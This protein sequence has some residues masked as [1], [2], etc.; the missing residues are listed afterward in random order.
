MLVM[1]EFNEDIG[2]RQ[3]AYSEMHGVRVNSWYVSITTVFYVRF[4]L[5]TFLIYA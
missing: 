2:Q 1:E 3:A 5:A 4:C